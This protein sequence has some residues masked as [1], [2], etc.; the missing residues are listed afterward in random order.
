MEYLAWDKRTNFILAVDYDDFYYLSREGA[1]GIFMPCPD[2]YTE[3][4]AMEYFDEQCKIELDAHKF[5]YFWKGLGLK[6]FS[7]V[8][9][10][11]YFL[12]WNVILKYTNHKQKER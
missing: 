2:C 12:K 8:S 10:W 11:V 6:I 3:E 5:F 1:N 4:Q 9:Y 7:C